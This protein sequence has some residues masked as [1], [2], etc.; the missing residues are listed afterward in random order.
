[1]SAVSTD[2]RLIGILR[3]N[4]TDTLSPG[5]RDQQDQPG[6]EGGI[7][8][9]GTVLPVQRFSKAPLSTTQPPLRNR[10]WEANAAERKCKADFG[11][12]AMTLGFVATAPPCLFSGCSKQPDGHAGDACRY[13]GRRHA[14]RCACSAFAVDR[15]L[16]F[17]AALVNHA[18]PDFS[19]IEESRQRHFAVR[20]HGTVLHSRGIV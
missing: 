18:Q 6:G 4:V 12:P 13:D 2:C 10:F 15:A 1:M 16:E 7:R 8:T 11:F 5:E 17:L 20:D 14:S 3:A 19:K 9:P